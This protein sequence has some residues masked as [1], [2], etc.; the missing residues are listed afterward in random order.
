M[1]TDVLVI[2]GGATGGGIAW[3]LALRGVHV[4]LVEMGD[5]ATG[6]SGRYHGLL[7]SGGRYA[8]RDP[9]SAHECSDENRIVRQIA[10]EAIEDTSGFFVL[11]PG[12]DLRY[13][14][15][16]IMGC[17]EAGIETRTVSLGEALKRERALNPKLQ[18]IY[19]VAD[20][21]CNSW[22][23]L[24]GLKKGAEATGLARFL[25]YH[26][27]ERFHKQGKRLVGATVRNLRN[28]ETFDVS[29]GCAI[30]AA[31][32]W[33][34]QIG[35]LAGAS[36][37][38]RLSR[39]AM[40]AYNLRWVN[41]VIN[42][43]RAP[44]DGDIFVP[45]GTVSVIGTTSV[46]TD[47]PGDTRV[48]SWE[49]TRIL[50]EAEAM[51]PG[52][53]RARILRAWGGVRPLYDPSSE[54]REARRTFT[55]LDHASH[56]LASD[57]IEGLISVLGGKLTT[58][59]LMAEKAS[60]AACAKIG[61]TAACATATTVLPPVHEKQQALH[62][63]RD[64]L[65][66]LE[67]GE[68]PGELICECEIVTKPQIIA[69]LKSGEV[70][71]LN[72]LRRDLR[73]GMGPCQGGFCAYRAAGIRHELLHDTPEH[74]TALLSEF[75]ER[76]F[77][78]M[79]PLLWGHNLRQALLAEHI[80]G[81]TL[82][83]FGGSVQNT[84]PHPLPPLPRKR[85]EGK[86]SRVVV[87][88][89]GLAGL[90]AALMCVEAGAKV[91]VIAQGQ[92]ALTLYH[93]GWI[94]TGNVDEL[95]KDAQHPYARAAES[96]AAGLALLDHV[97]RVESA[98]SITAFGSRRADTDNALP[99]PSGHMLI[100]GFAGWR[101]FYPELIADNMRKSNNAPVDSITIEM[102]NLGGNFDNW[103]VDLANWIDTDEG[104]ERVIAQVKPKLDDAVSVGF[105]AVLG[106]KG[107]AKQRI[108]EALGC[109]ISEIPTLPPSVPGL[110]LY[111]GLRR[112]IIDKGGRFSLG[113]RVSGLEMAD[114]RVMGV[115]AETAAH[116]R[117]RVVPADAVILATGGLF[118]GGLES[119]YQGR[120]WETVADLHVAN[121]PPLAEWFSHPL[122]SGLAQPIHRAGVMTD[123]DLRP[124]DAEG[125]VVAANLYAAGRLL[126]GYR[127]VVEGSTE[128]VDI[129]T[130]AHAAIKALANLG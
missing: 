70:V 71:E 115:R 124:L 23:L 86:T 116:G 32:P 25:T 102:P 118:G 18:A 84:P 64:R 21:T 98:V 67:H 41:T 99:K 126:S 130:G 29:F 4:L 59:R 47:D 19:E 104:I 17:A 93:P 123:G 40:L 7:H 80:Y 31:G 16:W 100:V 87:V 38:M 9:E 13:V 122:L 68:K 60:D 110:R 34:A 63:L 8:V 94:E 75:V 51:T 27:V 54:G 43:L 88:G 97:V 50:D 128:G 91:E 77:G 24:H 83:L 120:V 111:H 105:P 20:G 101:D 36:I 56:D 127:P 90:T 35:A 65:G 33:A 106:F 5:L 73:L 74:T 12:D 2:G 113:A 78:G 6:T 42:K 92:G 76:R 46:E 85:G 62:Q 52:I 89:A 103:S 79:K 14:D 69:A 44:G 53:S 117:A 15:Q 129:A 28:D 26:R 55:V 119:D 39:G 61:V 22:D 57:G 125:M 121:V 112:A 30:N 1:Q 107:E 109:P 3:D 82:G 58:F 37:K 45:V 11:C 72:D 96:L 95:M 114:G 66:A 81:R 49:V 10:P 48:E 108:A